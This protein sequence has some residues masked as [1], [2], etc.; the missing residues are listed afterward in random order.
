MSAAV[1]IDVRARLADTVGA[2]HVATVDL[3]EGARDVPLA[4][5]ADEGE[6][7]ELL[8]FAARDRLA[9]V[10]VGLGSKL[11]WTAP[12]AR[13]DFA[14]TTRRIAGVVAYEPGDGTLTA[15]AGST[16]A[17][18]AA[19]AR[20]GGHHVSP[21]VARPAEATLGGAIAAGESGCDRLR[22]GPAR[23]QVLGTRVA[24]ADATIARSGGR[25]VKTVT[26]FDLHRLHAGSHGTLC[27]ILEAS[28]RL[29]PLPERDAWILGSAASLEEALARSAAARAAAGSLSSIAFLRPP[30]SDARRSA[31][32]PTFARLRGRAEV[33]EADRAALERIW[34]LREVFADDE[35]RAHADEMR[36]ADPGRARE[37]SL[38]V[39]CAPASITRVVDAIDRACAA[40][41]VEHAILVEPAFATLDVRLRGADGG[42][43]AAAAAVA[44][45]RALRA[46]LAD[47]DA[48]ASVALR[49]A[50]IAPGAIDP[51]GDPG[52]A[53]AWMRRLKSALDPA[54]TFASGRFAGGL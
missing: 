7:L 17:S 18:L 13:A 52:P 24:L 27:V 46:A 15:R 42:P 16:I 36:D 35:A 48:D 30:P 37:A 9:L 3:G 53:L 47:A 4:A 31:H 54:G 28:L 6:L 32:W 23:H 43:V 33:L 49:N 34:P 41:R 44:L 40:A 19:V 21:D 1:G 12:P 5:P 8:R 29:H 22:C 20:S 50:R 38:R 25:L 45:T 14:L 26:G 39:G 10:P 2:A 11:G 51:F